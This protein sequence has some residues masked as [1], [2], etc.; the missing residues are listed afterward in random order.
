MSAISNR[1]TADDIVSISASAICL[2]S[3]PCIH[4]Y[5]IVLKDGRRLSQVEKQKFDCFDFHTMI[6]TLPAD[7]IDLGQRSSWSSLAELKKHFESYTRDK[8]KSVETIL[9]QNFSRTV[10][11]NS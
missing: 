1:L 8:V 9:N 7:K 2:Q 4:K 5:E 11:K 6:L 3:Y 10:G